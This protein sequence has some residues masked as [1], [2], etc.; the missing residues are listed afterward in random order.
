MSLKEFLDTHPG[1]VAIILV[2]A[3]VGVTVGVVQYIGSEREDSIRSAH[4]ATLEATRAGYEKQ[5][6]ELTTR[7]LSIDR[8]LADAIGSSSTSFFDIQNLYIPASHL[9]RLSFEYVSFRDNKFLVDV[10]PG[11]AWT[12]RDTTEGAMLK[13]TFGEA[14]HT[15]LPWLDSIPAIPLDQWKHSKTATID[16]PLRSAVQA[17]LDLKTLRLTLFP[18]VFVQVVSRAQLEGLMRTGFGDAEREEERRKKLIGKILE[19][20]EEVHGSTG[21]GTEDTRTVGRSGSANRLVAA[22][23]LLG[24]LGPVIANDTA[25]YFLMSILNQGSGLVRILDDASFTTVTV[26]KKGNVLYLRTQVVVRG[27]LKT[28]ERGKM[29][30]DQETIISSFGEDIILVRTQ[31]PSEH[32]PHEA[33]TW[34]SQWLTGLRVPLFV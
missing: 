19:T 5:I 1:P 4:I 3:T 26:Q 32:G 12:Y 11:D 25:G 28:K 22:D 15:L 21:R 7:L 33:Y 27:W 18:Y 31:V 29:I 2:I 34:I 30:V 23:Q 13:E 24:L 14:A 8:G 10:P 9:S 16:V 20:L 17:Q 6:S